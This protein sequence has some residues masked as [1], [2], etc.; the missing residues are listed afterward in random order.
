MKSQSLNPYPCQEAADGKGYE[1]FPEGGGRCIIVL[2]SGAADF[3]NTS[4]AQQAIVLSIWSD[5][6][7][8]KR[9]K[10]IRIADTVFWFIEQLFIFDESSVII[11]G[12]STKDD[13]EEIRHRMFSVWYYN[14]MK[15]NRT[16][17]IIKKD[18]HPEPREYYSFLYHADNPARRKIENIPIGHW[19]EK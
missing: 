6:T 12:C 8:E 13:Q 18:F 17:N 15:N 2:S 7:D 19:D 4:F 9:R 16:L 10:D 3:K 5:I 1:F 14:W 11:W